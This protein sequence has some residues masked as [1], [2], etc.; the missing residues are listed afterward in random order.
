[1]KGPELYTAAPA[2]EP[3]LDDCSFYQTIVLPGLGVIPGQ[4]D[5][6]PGI[7]E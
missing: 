1:M 4:W 3:A 2:V 5:L 6:R 7:A